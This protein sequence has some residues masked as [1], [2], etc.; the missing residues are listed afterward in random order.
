MKLR[1]A[2]NNFYHQ[3]F[4]KDFSGGGSAS[5][6]YDLGGASW[7]NKGYTQFVNEAYKK[8]VVANRCISLI[9]RSAASV[10]WYVADKISK[11]IIG[12]HQLLDLLHHP[13]SMQGGAEF[14]EALYAYKMISGNAYILAVRNGVG[15]IKE[16]HLLR[17]DR[18]EVVPG[19]GNVPKKYIYKVNEREMSYPVDQITGYSDV[20]HLKNFN[21]ADDWL[22]LSQ[23][24][25]ASYS[26]DIHNQAS[27]W[28]KSLLQN[29]ARP[30]GAM[31]V[32]SH[33]NSPGY[34]SD[35]Q[36]KRLVSQLE[37]K[38]MGSN[39][40]GRPIVLEGGLEWKEMGYS[41]KDMDFVET[42]NSAAR[43]I[44]LAFGIPP[45]LLGIKGDNTYNNMQ[46]ARLAFW[47]ETV[48]PLIDCTVDS[49]NNWFVDALGVKLRLFYN[50]NNISALS[51]KQEKIWK[52]VSEASFMTDDE[53]RSAVGLSGSF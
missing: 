27:T 39:N 2:V 9:S 51:L 36:F 12:N 25:S 32:K 20:L 4:K 44:A 8:N 41:P 31:I 11:K 30:T 43:D 35:D 37:E 40:A 48:L 15:L 34:L 10:G 1:H 45:Q 18:V 17:P 7:S 21:P 50:T 47:E 23:I 3:F 38:F 13:N 53:K 22:G 29:G 52:R 5:Y 24:E 6:L 19:K 16:L 46:E 28:N 49:L 26:I 33:N 42:K 14:F